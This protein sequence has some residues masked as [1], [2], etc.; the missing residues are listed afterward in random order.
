MGEEE[1]QAEGGTEGGRLGQ[2]RKEARAK[3]G[4]K[5]SEVSMNRKGKEMSEAR[6]GVWPQGAEAGLETL[7]ENGCLKGEVIPKRTRKG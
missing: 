4:P 2:R 5:K 7:W 1:V 6:R 3:A